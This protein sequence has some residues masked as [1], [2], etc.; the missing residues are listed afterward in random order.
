MRNILKLCLAALSNIVLRKCMRGVQVCRVFLA[1]T[2]RMGWRDAD[3]TWMGT[4]ESIQAVV[5][6]TTQKAGEP[7]TRSSPEGVSGLGGE[8]VISS[9]CCPVGWK[10]LLCT[11]Y[12]AC[13]CNFHISHWVARSIHR[14]TPIGS[15]E[16]SIAVDKW[17]ISSRSQDWLLCR[18]ERL[19]T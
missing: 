10:A 6:I 9:D 4:E 17:K 3:G 1:V 16:V 19:D 7:E 18:N 13:L 11:V 2:W 8:V 14:N 12:A 15:S 5:I